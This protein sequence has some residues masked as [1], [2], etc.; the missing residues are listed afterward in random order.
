MYRTDEPKRVAKPPTLHTCRKQVRTGLG[1]RK[2]VLAI[3][4]EEPRLGPPQI[5]Q[6]LVANTWCLPKA[7]NILHRVDVALFPALSKFQFNYEKM[8]LELSR[9]YE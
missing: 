8:A 3:S 5:Q 1:G 4:V 2:H 6:G 9:L 7:F